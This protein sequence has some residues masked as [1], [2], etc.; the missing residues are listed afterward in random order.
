M[1]GSGESFQSAQTAN[2]GSRVVPNLIAI[3]AS[4]RFSKFKDVVGPVCVTA[5]M[6]AVGARKPVNC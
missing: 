6:V 4:N 5:S 3:S 2:V 1:D